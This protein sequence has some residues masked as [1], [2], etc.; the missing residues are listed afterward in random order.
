MQL[1]AKAKNPAATLLHL[2]MS[3]TS[4]KMKKGSNWVNKLFKKLSKT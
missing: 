4:E 1:V 2:H 3:F